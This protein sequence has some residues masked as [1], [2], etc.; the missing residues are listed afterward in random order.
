V[1]VEENRIQLRQTRPEPPDVDCIQTLPKLRRSL[2]AIE[3]FNPRAA[4][5]VVDKLRK[6]L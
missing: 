2:L 5:E 4:E 3:R 6:E 1:L